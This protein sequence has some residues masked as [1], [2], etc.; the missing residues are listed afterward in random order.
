[1]SGVRVVSP[2]SVPLDAVVR[3]P[4]S[5]SQ[6]IRALVVSALAEDGSR[7]DLPLDAEDTRFARQALEQLGVEIENGDDAWVVTGTG[8]H[9]RTPLR[10]IDAGASGLTARAMIAVGSLVAG[11]TT[12]V[13]RDRLPQRPMNG[14]VHALNQLD[15]EVSAT[16]GGLPVTVAGRGALPGGSVA[17]DSGETTQFVTALLLVAPLATDELTIIPAGLEGSRRYLDVTIDTMRAFGG[18]VE[19]TG[20]VYR[21][22]PTGYT[23][24]DLAIEPDASAAVYPMVAAAITGGRVRVEGLGSGSL[25]P[26]MDIARVLETMGCVLEQTEDT[27]TVDARDRSLQPVDVDLSDAPDGALAI[28]VACLFADGPSRLRGLGSLRFKESDRLTAVAA[29]IARL[30]SGARIDGNDLLIDPATVGPAR[31]DT[32]GDHRLAMS[33]ALVGL[34]VPGMEIADPGV[35]GK[36]WPGY[37]DMIEGLAEPDP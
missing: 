19:E 25:Q 27:T 11:S 12:I 20:G 30:G 6:T 29:E 28:A 37:W 21:V 31:I 17:V 3:P 22:E 13:G 7:L 36:T 23:A 34:A 15:V 10:P 35:V 4:G 2:L 5:K 32:H 1:M 8:G 14:L 33:F 26:D 16:N 24:T 9:L 18:H